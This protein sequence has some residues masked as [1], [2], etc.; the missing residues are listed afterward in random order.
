MRSVLLLPLSSSSEENTGEV[1]AEPHTPQKACSDH[2]GHTSLAGHLKGM[3]NTAK[4][5]YLEQILRAGQFPIQTP[6]SCYSSFG[7]RERLVSK[8]SIPALLL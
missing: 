7:D 2:Q 6:D 4:N 1:T 5:I 8:G 3:G